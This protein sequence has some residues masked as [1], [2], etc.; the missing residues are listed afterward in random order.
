MRRVLFLPAAAA[1]MAL[2][3]WYLWSAS[4][5]AG[6]APRE[7]FTVGQTLGG[8]AAPGF[9][10]AEKPR[11][12]SFPADHGPHPGYRN[13]WWYFTGNL[14]GTDGRR[15]GYQL[16]FFKTALTPGGVARASAWATNQVYMAHFAVTDVQG[17]RFRFAERFSRGALGLAGA[18]GEPL[19]VRLDDWSALQTTPRPWGVRLAAAENGL[20]LDL[21]LVSVKPEVLNGAGGLSRK[22]A[23]PGNASYYYSIPRLATSGTLRIGGERF[24]VNG[25]SWLDREWSTSALEPDQVG[26]DWFA[27]Q[28]EDGRDL[29]FY[30]LRR[31]DG[32]SDPFSGGTLVAADG[33]SET[34]KRGDVRLEVV[35]WWES[36]ASGI[37]YP[38]V[39][40][41]RVPSARIAL[42]IVPRLAGQELLTGFRYWEGAV[43]V[44]GLEG[45]PGGTGYLEMTGYSGAAAGS[46]GAAGR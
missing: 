36:P 43:E 3:A 27:L 11:R 35:N 26:W 7:T 23:S 8:P 42:E 15:F 30:Q 6:N 2:L 31:R 45:S 38:S 32:R 46:A 39:W 12:F 40:R 21:N 19:A 28:L 9:L 37:R 13:E 33:R 4:R 1:V 34:L 29:M 24:D 18:S 17:R 5:P 22:G 20:A 41:L 44:R 16:T 25:L 10:R 14:K